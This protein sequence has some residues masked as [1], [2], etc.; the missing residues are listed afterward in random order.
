MR[1]LNKFVFEYKESIVLRRFIKLFSVDSFVK[2]SGIIF[3]P[4]YLHLMTQDEYAVFNYVLSVIGT[5]G[6]VINFG[7]YVSQIKL[8]HSL[9]SE[10]KSSLLYTIN[11]ILFVLLIIFVT[12][13]YFF[14]WDEVLV[15]SLFSKSIA[16]HHYRWLILIGM[17]SSVYSCMLLYFFMAEEFVTKQ[18]SYNITRFI[19]GTGVGVSAMYW[20]SGDNA[21]IRTKAYLFSE[22]FALTVFFRSYVAAMRPKVNWGVAMKALKIGLPIMGSA[23][24]GIFVNFS[25]KYFIEKYC[26]LADLSVYYLSFTLANIITIVFSAFQNV[27]LPLFLKEKDVSLNLAK[28]K[29]TFLVLGG[30][31]VAIALFIWFGFFMAIFFEIIDEKYSGVLRILPYA[32]ITCIIS[33]LTGLLSNYVI[34]WNMTFLTVLFGV[35]VACISLPLNYFGS[36]LYGILGVSVVG[37]LV[38]AVQFN[39][40]YIFILIKKKQCVNI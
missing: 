8:Y 1:I 3:L 14:G 15:K 27:W 10:E 19:I 20:L 2:V 28:T 39:L 33:G 22:I 31:F 36:K 25:D 12:P 9:C 30:V 26:S 34:Y 7:L 32:M 21:D 6:L 17:I 13:L 16:Y 18:Q 35:F 4:V 38:S 29:K 11:I 37:V 5:F 23:I 24:L 40:Y